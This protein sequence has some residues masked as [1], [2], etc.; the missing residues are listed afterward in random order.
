MP[1]E[2]VRPV[3]GRSTYR[4]IRSTVNNLLNGLNG[5]L[6]GL[7]RV[8]LFWTAFKRPFNFC[9]PVVRII[10]ITIRVFRNPIRSNLTESTVVLGIKPSTPMG[11][12]AA[13]IGLRKRYTTLNNVGKLFFWSAVTIFEF[14]K[15]VYTILLRIQCRLRI[16]EKKF[17]IS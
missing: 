9:P 5:M 14:P 12:I 1:F 10:S 2:K 6:N 11:K 4:L 17:R 3:Q 15:T 8:W 13:T 16:C 7:E